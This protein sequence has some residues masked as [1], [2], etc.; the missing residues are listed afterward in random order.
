MMNL[1]NSQ[2]SHDRDDYIC[3]SY[4]LKEDSTFHSFFLSNMTQMTLLNP[5]S[6]CLGWKNPSREGATETYKIP[7]NSG[8]GEPTDPSWFKDSWLFGYYCVCYLITHDFLMR[9]ATQRPMSLHLATPT[10]VIFATGTCLKPKKGILFNEHLSNAFS[11]TCLASTACV[12]RSKTLPTLQTIKLQ[13]LV[14]PEVQFFKQ[15]MSMT[16]NTK[17]W[18]LV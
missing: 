17:F 11:R 1:W 2:Q 18:C 8:V 7:S 4:F 9:L 3:F 13:Y 14:G 16:M 5:W 6:L 12:F 15:T 10:S